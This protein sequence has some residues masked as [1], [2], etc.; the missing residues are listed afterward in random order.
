MSYILYIKTSVCQSQ[1]QNVSNVLSKGD[2]RKWKH[3]TQEHDQNRETV[4]Q[5]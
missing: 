5:Q 2:L 4:V 1:K 3:I